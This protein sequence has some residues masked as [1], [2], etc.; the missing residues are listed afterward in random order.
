MKE[1]FE[2][3]FDVFV[4]EKLIDYFFYF[5]MFSVD[6]GDVLIYFVCGF[7]WERVWFVV[8]M[9]FWVC[10]NFGIGLVL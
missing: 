8:D 9:E 6:G 3:V 7:D 2:K 4:I 5:G 10:Y 1:C